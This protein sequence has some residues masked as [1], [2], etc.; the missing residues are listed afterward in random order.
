MDV[1]P[2]ESFS[3]DLGPKAV[4]LWDELQGKL[5][6]DRITLI[7]SGIAMI[8]LA[9][10]AEERGGRVKFGDRKLAPLLSKPPGNVIRLVPKK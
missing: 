8:E 2:V 9:V 5:K 7:R 6:C 1:E 3:M 10:R 4:A